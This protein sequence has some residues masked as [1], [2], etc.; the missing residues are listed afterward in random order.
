MRRGYDAGSGVETLTASAAEVGRRQVG[1]VGRDGS[2]VAFTGE[3][4][5]DY[6]GDI[7]GEDR[8]VEGNIL[9]GQATLEAM[10]NTYESTGDGL[11]ERLIAAL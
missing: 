10:A 1:V 2:V 6:A 8:T 4:C 7:Q 11:P 9:E 5:F 3:D